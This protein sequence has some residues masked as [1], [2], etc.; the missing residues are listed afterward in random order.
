MENK[1]RK[2]VLKKNTVTKL[3]QNEIQLVAA[4]ATITG[5]ASSRW[6]SPCVCTPI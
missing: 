2:L 6:T 1:K 4:G 5:C 3:T